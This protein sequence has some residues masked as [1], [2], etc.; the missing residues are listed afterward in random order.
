[1]LGRDLMEVLPLSSR[2]EH[3]GWEVL[4]WDIE[5]ID[6]RVEKETIAKIEGLK[7]DVVINAA[8][9]TDVDGCESEHE[10]AFAINAE[11]MRH[12]AL[13]A[14]RCGAKIVYLSTD[15]VF[16]GR[17]GRPYLEEDP[18]APLN[19]YGRSKLKGEEYV[20]EL[21]E[22]G[23]I[24]RTQWLYGKYGKN[25]VFTILRLA[26][27]KDVLSIVDDQVGAPTYTVDL[28]WAISRLIQKDSRGIFH[29]ANRDGCSWYAF[30][31]AILDFSGLTRVRVVPASSKTLG[32]PARRPS[33]S[34][35][36]TGRLEKETGASLRPW[37][38]ALK[39]FLSTCK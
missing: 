24:I 33:Y 32:R 19:V 20:L 31:R 5:E 14:S 23:L 17:K 2:G 1:M 21:S 8:A 9:F 34:V 30:A 16:D 36:D 38:E 11:G 26:G 28:A 3:P 27:E 25:F 10:K 12:V 15:Y 7:P 37:K 13:G 4:G 22:N 39:D 35:L 18:T 6:I 29:A